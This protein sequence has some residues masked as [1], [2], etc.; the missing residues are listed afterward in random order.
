[1]EESA[2]GRYTREGANEEETRGGKE[3]RTERAK[4]GKNEGGKREGATEGSN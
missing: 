3:L 1:V 2:S 4:H